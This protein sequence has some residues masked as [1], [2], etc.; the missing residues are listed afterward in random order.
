MRWSP[1]RQGG[2]E[3]HQTEAAAKNEFL[4]DLDR[5]ESGEVVPA[6]S[7]DDGNGDMGMGQGKSYH[8]DDS[9][10]V[11]SDFLRLHLH[12]KSLLMVPGHFHNE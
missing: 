12:S 3:V 8:L 5:E 9:I 1:Y 11:W 2:V 10:E 6:P 7:K 4:A